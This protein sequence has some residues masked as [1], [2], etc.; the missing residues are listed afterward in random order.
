MSD[1]VDQVDEKTEE[2][3][4]QIRAILD[5]FDEMNAKV[6]EACKNYDDLKKYID[7]NTEM[8]KEFVSQFAKKLPTPY[9]F[10]S[11]GEN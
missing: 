11:E 1:K 2:N 10:T 9:N 4:K 7:D 8:L 5:Q 6:H 3:R